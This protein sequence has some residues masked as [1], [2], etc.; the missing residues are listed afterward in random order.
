MAVITRLT[1]RLMQ[2]T[3]PSYSIFVGSLFACELAVQLV[4]WA[5]CTKIEGIAIDF[6]FAFK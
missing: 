6:C 5:W 4:S 3:A 1:L 2:N